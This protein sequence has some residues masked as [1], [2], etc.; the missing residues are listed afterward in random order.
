VR[1]VID[2]GKHKIKQF[3]NKLGLDSLLVKPISRSS[4]IQRTGRAGREAPGKCIRLFTEKDF[5]G[6]EKTARP[7]ILRC[8]LAQA[9]VT[10]K[11]R[12]VDDVVGFPWLDPPPT[13]A[14]QKALMQLYQLGALGEDGKITEVGKTIAKLPLTPS[15]GRVLVEAAKPERDCLREVIDVVAAL[16]VE[17]IF[18]NVMS[19]EKK[20]EAEAARAELYRREGDHLTLL[21]AVRS[22]SAENTDRKKWAAKYFVSHRAMQNVMDIRKQLTQLC[23]A[24]DLLDK[25]ASLDDISDSAPSEELNAAILQCIL[26]GFATNTARLVPD[27]SYRTAVSNQTVAIHPSSVLFGK[28][29]EAV[30]F[31]EYVFTTKS[32]A[33]GCSAVRLAWIDEALQGL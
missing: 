30:V 2:S 5:E 33:R 32:Y 13:E 10:M 16:S 8:D 11:A 9:I 25:N 29:L 4:A 6:L 23:K 31:T 3:R 12:G 26:R 7:E 28:K 18:L 15:L 22:Y 17:N 19:E 1:F 24:L 20:E 27:G 21:A 14:L